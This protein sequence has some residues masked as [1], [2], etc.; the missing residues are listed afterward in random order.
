M[1]TGERADDSG[2]GGALVADDLPLIRAGLRLVAEQSGF[3]DVLEAE[4]VA[5]L[6]N[7]IA[8]GR[9]SLLIVGTSLC[10]ADAIREIPAA[11]RWNP[12][13]RIVATGPQGD[14]LTAQAALRAGAHSYVYKGSSVEELHSAVRAVLAGGMYL[15]RLLVGHLLTDQ[16]VERVAGLSRRELEVLQMIANG[17]TNRQIAAR[18]HMGVR[19]VEECR[20]G[21]RRK[22]GLTDRSELTAFARR[23]AGSLVVRG[24]DAGPRVAAVGGRA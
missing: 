3:R 18:L 1:H 14:I 4:D 11:L 9:P 7:H 8:A 16:P 19:T 10:G 2:Y 21:I 24:Y 15:D 20:A 6:R 12:A 22:T 23:V 17:L 13:I 5:E